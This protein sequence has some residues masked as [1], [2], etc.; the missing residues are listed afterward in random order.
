MVVAFR[1]GAHDHGAVG[2]AGQGAR[3]DVGALPDLGVV[4]LVRD[5]PQIVADGGARD[6][7][8]RVG[9]IDRAGRVVGRVHQ[10]GARAGGPCGAVDLVEG[11]QEGVLCPGGDGVRDAG[12]GADR[13]GIGGIVGVDV[14]AGLAG[15]QRRHVRGKERG[16]PAGGHQHVVA[17]GGNAGAVGDAAG[18]AVAQGVDPGHHGVA[19]VPGGGGAVHLFEDRLIGADVMLADGQFEDVLALRLQGA[20][21]VEHAPAVG[22]VAVEGADTLGQMRH[23]RL[24]FGFWRGVPERRRLGKP[25]T[26]DAEV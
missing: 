10:Q 9:P 23:G 4:D 25:L 18:D 6:A 13:A 11:G 14:E 21:L 12:G 8:E 3:A 20:R 1:H 2:H 19:G 26:F 16:L 15:G 22:A 17:C 5:Q 7:V 24:L